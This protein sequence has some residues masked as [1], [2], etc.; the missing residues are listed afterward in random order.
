MLRR[1]SVIG[2]ERST[3]FVSFLVEAVCTKLMSLACR[4]GGLPPGYDP[5]K[6]RA[7]TETE[8]MATDEMQGKKETIGFL[9]RDPTKDTSG[10]KPDYGA[11]DPNK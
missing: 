2:F 5:D 6:P 8:Q 4:P 9:G 11:A 3:H 7:A 1:G 10:G